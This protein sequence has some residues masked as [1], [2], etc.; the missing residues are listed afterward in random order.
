MHKP[1]SVC[2]VVR[3]KGM[4]NVEKADINIS[5]YCTWVVETSHKWAKPNG[6]QSVNN[7]KGHINYFTWRRIILKIS[8]LSRLTYLYSQVSRELKS[9][10]SAKVTVQASNTDGLFM[11]PW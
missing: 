9:S 1:D 7:A 5:N 8:L 6:K 4:L 11:M 3:L 10:C 2:K